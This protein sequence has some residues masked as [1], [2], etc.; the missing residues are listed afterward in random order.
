MMPQTISDP[1]CQAPCLWLFDS[2][3]CLSTTWLV[4]YGLT[5]SACNVASHIVYWLVRLSVCLF[6]CLGLSVCG[7]INVSCTALSWTQKSFGYLRAEHVCLFV[8]LS[9]CLFLCLPVCLYPS[10]CLTEEVWVILAWAGLKG[11]WWS[12]SGTCRY[13]TVRWLQNTN[14]STKQGDAVCASI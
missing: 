1:Y 3:C 5:T 11:I 13:W 12:D 7:S 2:I 14:I 10:V 6:W 8:C 4:L 9:I